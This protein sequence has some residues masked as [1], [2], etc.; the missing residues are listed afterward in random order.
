MST[1]TFKPVFDLQIHHDYYSSGQ[2]PDL[3]IR[4]AYDSLP[5]IKNLDLHFASGVSNAM[6]LV[7]AEV[8]EDKTKASEKLGEYFKLTFFITNKNPYFYNF[9]SL[10]LDKPALYNTDFSAAPFAT[11]SVYY[12]SNLRGEN[13]S[14]HQGEFAGKEDLVYIKPKTFQCTFDEPVLPSELTIVDKATEETI[15]TLED[16]RN[17]SEARTQVIVDLEA[18]ECGLYSLKK[19][20][21]AVFDFYA[22]NLNM[23]DQLFGII[24]IHNNPSMPEE[25]K[26]VQNDLSLTNK[27]FQISFEARATYWHYILNNRSGRKLE[28]PAV[29]NG[30][31]SLGFERTDASTEDNMTSSGNGRTPSVLSFLSKQPIKLREKYKSIL[32]LKHDLNGGNQGTIILPNLPNAGV[33]VIKPQRGES[34]KIISEINIYL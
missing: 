32:Q 7:D 22:V 15:K 13:G 34:E 9:T 6:L 20:D 12:F 16:E 11:Q 31:E 21:T 33:K 5:K 29:M 19:G 17:G 23:Q 30:K 3:N 28:D 4:P 10:P 2:C 18:Y 14:L 26:M 1:T 27:S 25:S 8:E 24:E